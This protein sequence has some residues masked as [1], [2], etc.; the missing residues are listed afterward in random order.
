MI[1]IICYNF[2][3]KLKL[4]V[5]VQH[6]S[7]NANHIRAS[8]FII[9]SLHCLKSNKALMGFICYVCICTLNHVEIA[10]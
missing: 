2:N 10:V 5:S 8:P 1:I 6:R 4:L 3:Y 9:V 7:L